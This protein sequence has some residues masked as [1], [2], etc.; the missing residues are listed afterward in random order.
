VK[1]AVPELG[2][3]LKKEEKLESLTYTNTVIMGMIG[4]SK[5]G[6]ARKKS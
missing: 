2:Q 6:N 4:K 3:G 1:S 5:S